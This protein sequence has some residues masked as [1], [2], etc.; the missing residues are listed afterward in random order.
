LVVEFHLATQQLV[1]LAAA[2]GVKENRTLAPGQ[3][4]SQVYLYR[5]R[6]LPRLLLNRL[7]TDL[8]VDPLWCDALVICDRSDGERDSTAQGRRDQLDR[9]RGFTHVVVTAIDF[10][11]SVPDLDLCAPL[12]VP[13]LYPIL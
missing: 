3:A 1:H 7:A 12:A 8:D 11:G 2:G 4:F 9:A 13:N 5:K 6:R 10:Q